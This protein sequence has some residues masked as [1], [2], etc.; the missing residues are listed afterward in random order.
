[1][2][3]ISIPGD[4]VSELGGKANALASIQSAGQRANVNIPKWFVVSPA[5]FWASLSPAQAEVLSRATSEDEIEVAL[6]F[7]TCNDDVCAEIQNALPTIMPNKDGLAVRSSAIDEDGKAHSFAGQ[8]ESFLQVASDDL[9]NK[10]AAVW[11]SGFSA[12]VL[13]YR[14]ENNLGVLPPPPA[15]L[16]QQMVN[17]ESAGVAF[18]ADP[19]SGR[20]SVVVISAVSGLGQGLVAGEC[21]ADTYH[22]NRADEII[23]RKLM[24]ETPILSDEQIKKIAAL[25]RTTSQHFNRPQDIEWAIE[26]GQLYLLQ[27]RPITTIAH[28]ADPDGALNLW[29]NS[30]IAESYGGVTTPLTFS[31]ARRAYEEV[32]RQFCRLM[33]V[34]D[35]T[36]QQHDQTFKHMLGLLGGRVYYNLLNWY[37]VLAMLPGFKLNRRFMEQMM[38]VKEGLPE[39]LL[40]EIGT[41]SKGE[42]LRDALSLLRTM[43]GLV[44]NHFLLPTKI[45]SFYARLNDALQASNPPLE[46]MRADELAAYYRRIEAQLLTRWDAPLINDFFAM[47][48]YGLLRRLSEKWC[49][50]PSGSLQNALLSESG[51]II[52][53][54]PAK[55]I[56][57]M[58][59]SLQGNDELV[60]L[61]CN[62][63]LPEI[64]ARM[65]DFSNLQSQISNYLAEFGDRC[66]DEL[67]LE[68]HTLHDDPLLLFRA[69]GQAAK[70]GHE[71]RAPTSLQSEA[72]QRAAAALALHPLRK[73]VFHWVLRHAR[74][75]VREREN[76]RFERT[77]LFGRA[78]RLFLE[79][80][81]RFYA[82]NLLDDPRD[83]FYLEVEE[84]LGFIEG[85]ATT[86]DLRGMVAVRKVEFAQH[87]KME[88]PADRFATHGAVHQGN[89]FRPIK[90]ASI[91]TL[92]DSRKGLACSPGIVRGKVRV[93]TD[94]RQAVL[95]PGEILV[96]ERT[97]PGWVLLFASAAGLL[98]ER[99]SLLSHAAIVSRE[100]RLPAIV[101]IPG[102]TEWLQDG[103]EVEFDGSTG[104]VSV[105]VARA[106]ART[107]LMKSSS[108]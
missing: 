107:G 13:A 31:F 45:K 39:H 71:R 38:G 98:V 85:A 6:Q 49:G 44:R 94:P 105:L 26:A 27:S 88:A 59:E 58:A 101:A 50:D 54:E 63:A 36:I 89:Q 43:G 57:A 15:V 78:R 47:I 60:V 14:R 81:Q 7:L 73:L 4:S 108:C 34:P 93:V 80:G 92:G 51:G 18:A 17:A 104:I 68:S 23:E 64:N 103:D 62:G 100:M 97:D 12:R 22:V 84:V 96:A 52:S 99:G 77:R 82:D 25:V 28:L 42:K 29:D 56:R 65:S 69:I 33:L 8:L 74:D 106:S 86:T 3:F 5:A 37:R 95:Q 91:A 67:K 16:I 53:A 83:V 2:R 11:R 32:Y 79:L 55:R 35:A 61:L 46:A 10:I 20:R 66:L 102:V 1:M 76:L 75:R 24:A 41:I 70:N 40:A 90:T 9:A 72:E 87:R 30:N 48:F 21:N 19:I